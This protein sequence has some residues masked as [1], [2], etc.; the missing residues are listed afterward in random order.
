MEAQRGI[1]PLDTG[2]CAEG[3]GRVIFMNCPKC[4]TKIEEGSLYCTACGEDIHIVPDFESEVEQSMQDTLEQ[5]AEELQDSPKADTPEKKPQ[6]KKGYLGWLTGVF[7]LVIMILAG[8]IIG[9]LYHM[10]HSVEYQMAR[11]AEC[12]A[13][14]NYQQA[15]DYY[16]RALELGNTDQELGFAL[17]DCYY[18]MDDVGGYE[19][20]LLRMIDGGLLDQKQLERAYSQLIQSYRGRNDYQTIDSLLNSCDNDVIRSTYQNLQARAPEFGFEEGYYQEILPLKLSSNT[21]GTIYYTLDGSEP[22]ENSP[23]YTA[24]IFLD[25]GEHTV[26][27]VFVNQYGLVSDV[28]TKRYQIEIQIPVA[29]D[30]TT[31]SGEY[32][33]PTLIKINCEEEDM[34]Y[35][36][37]DGTTPTDNSTRYTGPI[38]MPL[39][40]SVYN[41]AIIEEGGIVGEVAQ[42]SYSLR[43][44][45]EITVDTA[46][47]TVY[48]EMLR[49]GRIVNYEGFAGENGV[50]QYQLQYP[51]TVGGED[52]YIFAEL[53]VDEGGG[54][55]RTGSYYAVHVYNGICYK[56]LVDEAGNYSIAEIP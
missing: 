40:D 44:N 21:A 18:A 38:P 46:T 2:N 25:N 33:S 22:D 54:S 31:A 35:Y 1:Y 49:T 5:I 23:I 55:I 52:F 7:F 53:H 20:Q 56:L 29:P 32:S 51:L 15:V 39:G 11:A 6:R 45:T 26:K 14:Q 27:A 36:T 9:A 34:I 10:E 37:T 4:G 8:V 50:Y 48:N 24:P 3:K 42:R 28:V 16:L 41:F 12:V 13:K 30:V 47:I 17:A 19:S 43:L